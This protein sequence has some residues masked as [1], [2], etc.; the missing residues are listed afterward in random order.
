M[1]CA[2]VLHPEGKH[3]MRAPVDAVIIRAF[4]GGR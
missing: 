3:L 1:S 2:A 4:Q